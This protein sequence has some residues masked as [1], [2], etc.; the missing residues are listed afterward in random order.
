[1]TDAQEVP[2]QSVVGAALNKLLR[3]AFALVKKQVFYQAPQMA[4][5]TS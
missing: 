3:V 5:I 4:I 2:G 1:M